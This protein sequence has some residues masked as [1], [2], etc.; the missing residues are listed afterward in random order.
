M[1]RRSWRVGREALPDARCE[2]QAVRDRA[3]GLSRWIER[4]YEE[5]AREPVVSERLW[6]VLL[7]SAASIEKTADVLEAA[8]LR[9]GLDVAGMVVANDELIL[10]LQRQVRGMDIARDALES[11]AR[12]QPTR[13]RGKEGGFDVIQG[14]ARQTLRLLDDLRRR[15]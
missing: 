11:I 3:T 1:S 7:E 12:R 13:R 4:L 5:D 2:I 10:G 14:F 9:E 8:A 15:P 6:K